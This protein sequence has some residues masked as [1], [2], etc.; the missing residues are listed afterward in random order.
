MP[1]FSGWY[2]KDAII[3]AALAFGSFYKQHMLLFILPLIT[4]G[5]TTFYMFR[6]WFMTFTGEPRDA[7]VH[8]HAHES[9]WLMTVPLIVL[10][11]FSIFVAWGMPPW[12]AAESQL[13]KQLEHSR[14]AA[15]TTDWPKSFWHRKD[16][17]GPRVPHDRRRL[18]ALSMVVLGASFAWVM[19]YQGLLDPADAKEQF[20]GVHRFLTRKWWFDEF[21][22]A[23]IVRPGLTIAHWAAAF[24]KYVIDGIVHF[25]ARGGVFASRWSGNVDRG[26]VDGLV[27]V[28]GN[29]CYAVGSWLRTLQTGYL[30]SYV[31]F[32]ALA[33]IAIWFLLM[34]AWSVWGGP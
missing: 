19:Y 29:V 20:P 33:A 4:A 14:P 7:H 6:M 1:L 12:E 13:A 26:I 32:L 31:L 30:R 24:D 22:S 15:V 9:P 28:F 34:S 3:V 8:E 10:A 2:S 21:Y 16:P 27:N 18:L 17:R 25:V 23:A 5:I 11:C